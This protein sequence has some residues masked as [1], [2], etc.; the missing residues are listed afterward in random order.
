MAENTSEMSLERFD[1]LLK[2]HGPEIGKWPEMEQQSA[3]YLLEHSAAAKALFQF[4]RGVDDLL[5]SGEVP[6]APDTLI[7]RIMDKAKKS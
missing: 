5:R 1:E 4:E 2:R 6:K 7:D 3:R